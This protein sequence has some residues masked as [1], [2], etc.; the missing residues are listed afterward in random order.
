[1]TL[2]TIASAADRS[3]S[4]SDDI[5]AEEMARAAQQH[6]ATLSAA[7]HNANAPCDSQMHTVT[8]LQPTAS[9]PWHP[10]TGAS[11]VI[12]QDAAAPS[13]LGVKPAPILALPHELLLHIFWLTVPPHHQ[14][15]PSV[16]P[17]P[18]SAWLAALRTRKSLALTCRAF[19]GPATEVLYADIVLRRMGQIPALARTLTLTPD[20]DSSPAPAAD[21]GAR[22]AVRARALAPLVRSLRIDAC[23]VWAPFADVVREDLGAVLRRCTAL[24]AF[25]FRPH[26]NFVFDV[27]ADPEDAFFDAFDSGWLW[28]VHPAATG[29]LYAPLRH[30]LR[31][32][33]LVIDI[34][35]RSEFVLFHALLA[36]AT[37]LEEFSLEF[38]TVLSRRPNP[39]G[40]T[41]HFPALRDL[42]YRGASE[43]A[44]WFPAYVADTW[45]APQ[46]RALTLTART[47]A[48]A[49][50]ITPLLRAHGARLAYLHWTTEGPEPWIDDP[51]FSVLLWYASLRAL[52]DLAQLC[53]RLEHLVIARD[54]LRRAAG[55]PVVCSPTLR[56][57]DVACGRKAPPPG[58]AL[59]N[60]TPRLERDVPVGGD[61]VVWR[62]PGGRVVQTA[63]GVFA[64]D[65]LSDWGDDGSAEADEYERDGGSGDGFEEGDEDEDEGDSWSW[66]SEDFVEDDLDLRGPPFA[67]RVSVDRDTMLAM[68]H[69]SQGR[70]VLLEDELE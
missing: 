34:N 42:H 61:A 6:K 48:A 3:P 22:A 28:S 55:H 8:C 68:F 44:T 58:L 16:I 26:R 31:V 23:V 56:F 66:A 67:G 46:L 14:H 30:G 21:P 19:L 9:C 63:E 38:S 65:A 43:K 59:M 37:R 41:I 45:A 15:D 27:C 5:I 36:S 25:A 13:R 69:D 33:D 1:M 24:R 49:Y 40:P 11:N 70:A 2:M 32:L 35:R 62:F 12:I 64:E 53:P 7:F 18:R 52:R 39:L 29:L 54:A 57:L 20:A 51:P 47:S 60:D 10:S 17:G 50:D 4:D